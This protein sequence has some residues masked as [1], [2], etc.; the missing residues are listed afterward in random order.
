MACVIDGDTLDLD[1]C[2]TGERLRLL[3]I[4][5]PEAAHDGEPAECGAA[6][7][8]GWLTSA[9]LGQD[10]SLTYDQEC[11]GHFGRTLVY[12]WLRGDP[13][14]EMADSNGLNDL[15]WAWDGDNEQPALLLNEAL[16]A[17]GHAVLYP[18]SS[19]LLQE[20]L[21]RAAALAPAGE[22]DNGCLR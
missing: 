5:A 4:D 20:R 16:L 1:A 15:L 13:A 17:L 21:D 14:I 9:A 2:G 22:H 12:A 19:L 6:Q 10:L 8:T 3:G 11:F 7:A 18:G